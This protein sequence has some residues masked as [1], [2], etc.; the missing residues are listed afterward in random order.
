MSVVI[1]AHFDG[2]VLVPDEPVELPQDCPLEIQVR[3]LSDAEELSQKD[4][5]PLYQLIGMVPEGPT[6]ASIHHD[7]RPEELSE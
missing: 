2:S 3:I 5:T 4:Y 7:I 1:R 6:D